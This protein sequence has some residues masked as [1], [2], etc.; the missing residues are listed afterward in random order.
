[1]DDRDQLDFVAA[2]VAGAVIGVGAVL[3]LRSEPPSRTERVLKELEPYRKRLR[4]GA[5]K[6]RKKAGKRADR[7]VAGGKDALSD[8][9]SE[10]ADIVADAKSEIA[11][12]V[13]DSV[14]NAQDAVTRGVKKIRG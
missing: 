3:L 14:E 13:D 10:I 1:M 7:A 2:F 11:R 9:R 8:L 12:A 4:K 5:K 6:V